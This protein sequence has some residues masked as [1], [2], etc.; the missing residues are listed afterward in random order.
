MYEK[1][2]ALLEARGIT[3]YQVSKD[4]GITKS[5][6][7]DWKNGRSRPGTEKLYILSKYFNVPMEYFMEDGQCTNITLLLSKRKG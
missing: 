5:T 6:F 7:T 3:A 2:V 4:T 1:F